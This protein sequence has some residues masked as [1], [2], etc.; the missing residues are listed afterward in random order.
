MNSI[1]KNLRPGEAL[2]FFV[3]DLMKLLEQAMLGLDEDA[4]DI[5]LD[6]AVACAQLLM[7]V[8]DL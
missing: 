6:A 1:K 5:T 3:H 7:A 8:E 4:R 2:S